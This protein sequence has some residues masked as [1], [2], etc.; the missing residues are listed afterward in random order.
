MLKTI[1][2]ISIVEENAGV[3]VNGI[4]NPNLTSV[5]S[6]ESIETKPEKGKVSEDDIDVD[7]EAV[8]I[9]EEKEEEETPENSESEDDKDESESKDKEAKKS[10]IEPDDSKRVQKRIAKLTKKMR[11]A[12]RERDYEKEKRLE[13]EKEL[14]ELA[15]KIPDKDKPLKADFDDEDE[16]IEALTDW[17]IDNKLKTSQKTV[18]KETK[19]SEEKQAITETYEGL[20]DAME[21]GREK[22]EDFNEIVLDEDLIIS[23]TVTQ[24]LLDTDIPDDIMYYLGNN[25][26]KS[27]KISQL[28]P[29]R[30]AKEIGKI[31]VSL[32]NK[33]SETTPEVKKV[34]KKQSKAPAPIKPVRANGLVEK[35]PNKM[36][37]KEY[38]EWR[39]K[40]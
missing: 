15:A 32:L 29:I 24:I 39:A 16:Y 37:P 13:V 33:S 20:D 40:Q 34:N 12:E 21:S 5:D 36:S 38:R 3:V 10:S 14:Q 19:D 25:P 2:E 28:D 6:T 4:D 22:Y 35:D 27:E 30:A 17:I 23:P 31:E 11:T 1:E 9:T 7:E 8:D 26:E 18:E